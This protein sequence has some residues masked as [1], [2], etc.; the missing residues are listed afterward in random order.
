MPT[1]SYRRAE[2]LREDRRAILRDMPRFVVALTGARRGIDSPSWFE[3][4]GYFHRVEVG[5]FTVLERARR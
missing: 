1:R 4:H 5:S 3:H 2:L